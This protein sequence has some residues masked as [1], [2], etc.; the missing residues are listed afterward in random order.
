MP[1]NLT[2]SQSCHHKVVT[3]S[4]QGCHNVVNKVV[5]CT[6]LI[7][8]MCMVYN[9]CTRYTAKTC[10]NFV[11]ILQAICKITKC[12]LLQVDALLYI[13]YVAT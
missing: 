10:V 13:M 3:V 11:C 7:F 5:A 8:C 1:Y 9:Q 2:L 4:K 12:S 6:T